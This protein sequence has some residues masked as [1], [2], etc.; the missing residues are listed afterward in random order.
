MGRVFL[1]S[2]VFLPLLSHCGFTSTG[3]AK[4]ELALKSATETTTVTLTETQTLEAVKSPTVSNGVLTF[5]EVKPS[6]LTVSW[7][8][9]TEEGVDSLSYTVYYALTN[10]IDTVLRAKA[11]GTVAGASATDVAT[12]SVTGLT[13][14]S[15]YYFNVVVEDAVGNTTAY[16]MGSQS[17]GEVLYLFNGGL[18]AGGNFGGRAGADAICDRVRAATY[19]TVCPNTASTTHAFL[20]VSSTDEVANFPMQYSTMPTT[21]PILDAAYRYQ[22]AA[23]WAELLNPTTG[24]CNGSNGSTC[25]ASG[26]TSGQALPVL[27]G[28]PGNAPLTLWVG[29]A[30]ENCSNWSSSTTGLGMEGFVGSNVGMVAGFLTSQVSGCSQSANLLC[31]CW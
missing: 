4:S 5:S 25:A 18:Q 24:P 22:V 8:L 26:A 6:S 29:S 19:T 16:T 23:N 17:M 2:L 1:Y 27:L 10:T 9:A 30:T 11:N 12:L 28:I 15:T 21:V 14:N 13:P 31:L 20:T 3:V 7:T